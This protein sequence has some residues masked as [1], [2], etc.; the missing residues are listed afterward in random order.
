MNVFVPVTAVHPLRHRLIVEIEMYR[1][2][3]EMHRNYIRDDGR[4]AAFLG[5]PPDTATAEGVRRFEVERLDQWE[6]SSEWMT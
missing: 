5:R 4:F 6:C 3:C 1:F 2:G